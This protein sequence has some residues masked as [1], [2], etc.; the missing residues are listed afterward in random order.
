MAI[1]Q[2]TGAFEL[3]VQ[4]TPIAAEVD[5][6][7]ALSVSVLFKGKVVTSVDKDWDANRN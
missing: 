1:S 6:F 5:L 7:G 4:P 3:M 2:K